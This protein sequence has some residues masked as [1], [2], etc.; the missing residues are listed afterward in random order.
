MQNLHLARTELPKK[1]SKL[2]PRRRLQPCL[3]R[4]RKNYKERSNL[5]KK[6]SKLNTED[7]QIMKDIKNKK[8]NQRK[9]QNKET[10]DFD[11]LFN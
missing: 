11:E 1:K 9:E 3:K 2:L 4:E 8:K 5:N 7:K 6:T 10:D